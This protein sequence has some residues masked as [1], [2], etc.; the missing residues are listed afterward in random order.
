MQLFDVPWR[1]LPCAGVSWRALRRAGVSW[2]ALRRAGV[3]VLL[4]SALALRATAQTGPIPSGDTERDRAQKEIREL[5]DKVERR[6]REIDRLLSD[7]GAGDA[8]ALGQ[9]LDSGMEGLLAG[10]RQRGREVVDGIDR[11]LELAQQF[12]Q[13]STGSCSNPS[14]DPTSQEGQSPVDRQG[15]QSTQRE[16][17]PSK[18]EQGESPGERPRRPDTGGA[19]PRDP[20]AAPPSD[21]R[22]TPGSAPPG[23]PTEPPSASG[24]SRERWGELPVHARDVFR[25]EGGSDLPV[26]YRDWIDAYYRRLNRR[27]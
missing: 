21:P 16:P 26:Q 12:P 24:D 10:T 9:D 4:A 11:I 20:R 15:E 18:P 8:S 2:R 17:T 6:L 5:F 13:Q 1:S 23:Q 27:P 19:D 25:T 3:F 14:G 7:A 22:N